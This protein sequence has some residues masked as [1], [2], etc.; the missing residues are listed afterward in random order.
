MSKAAKSD[1]RSAVFWDDLGEPEQAGIHRELAEYQRHGAE[2]ERQWAELVDPKAA[3]RPARGAE[4]AR[5]LT[6]KNAEHVSSALNRTADAL[7]K[8]ARPLKSM[9][10]GGSEL[11]G[12]IALQ[13]S[14]KATARAREYA[15]RARSQAEEWVSIGGNR[16]A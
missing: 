7:E 9:A 6:R 14:V 16:K 2:L 5:S 8:A 13:G 12:P 11:D 15:Q 3:A 10:A 1:D 4:R